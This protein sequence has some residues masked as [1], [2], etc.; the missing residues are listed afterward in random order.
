MPCAEESKQQFKKWREAKECAV[1]GF[2]KQN[3]LVW[4]AATIIVWGARCLKWRAHSW[5]E[6]EKICGILWD[7]L[8]WN[9]GKARVELTVDCII[10]LRLLVLQNI[11][12]MKRKEFS[13]PLPNMLF[14][15]IL[16]TYCP[17]GDWKYWRWTELNSTFESNA[18]FNC[19]SRLK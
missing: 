18:T 2:K 5:V 17:S 13:S 10:N 1:R 7:V 3:I 12:W 11:R 4:R 19:L 8:Q 14:S 15:A 6:R 9:D 16:D